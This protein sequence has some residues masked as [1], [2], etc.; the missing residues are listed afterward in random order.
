MQLSRTTAPLIALATLAALALCPVAA[1]AQTTYNGAD[2]GAGIGDSHPNTSAA[3]TAFIADASTLGTINTITFESAPVGYSTSLALDPETTMTASNLDPTY[4]DI[5]DSSYSTADGYNTT[6]FGTKFFQ[7]VNYTFYT[8]A[9]VTFTFAQP[10][11]AFGADFTGLESN[12]NGDVALTFNDGSAQSYAIPK[13][14][15]AGDQFFGFTDAG[16]SLSSVTL[17]Q[18]LP[19]NG[20]S[21]DFFGIDQVQYG[22]AP[23]AAPEPS[24]L[25][26]FAV[27]SLA[28]AA[29]ILKAKRRHA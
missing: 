20:L 25:T 27:M 11:D 14:D 5:S 9:S 6:L 4:S 28:A 13:P 23:S 21:R 22:I 24:P 12:V 10:I 8:T 16:K 7:F 29:L 3:N 18:V 26:A 1:L 15:I 2:P 17:T 19:S